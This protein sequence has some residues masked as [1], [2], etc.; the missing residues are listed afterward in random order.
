MITM[1]CTHCFVEY[2][3]PNELNRQALLQGAALTFWCPLGHRQSYGEG[4]IEIERRNRQRAEQEV[5][6]LADVARVAE[7]RAA[8]A[9]LAEAAAKKS[10]IRHK[11]RSIAGVCPCCT[12][13]F[14]N[15]ARHM[16]SEHPNYNVVPLKVT[17]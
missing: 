3:I 1:Q 9:E 10:L 13:T 5:A 7:R 2:G 8:G 4:Q 12:R 15:M 16:K 14:T 11:K 17:A 6:R